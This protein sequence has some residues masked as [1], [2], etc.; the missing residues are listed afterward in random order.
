MVRF[1]SF[2]P[3]ITRSVSFYSL[4][5]SYVYLWL[6]SPR[7]VVMSPITVDNTTGVTRTMPGSFDDDSEEEFDLDELSLGIHRLGIKDN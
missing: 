2:F 6:D 3:S 5:P 7:A 1:L 4:P